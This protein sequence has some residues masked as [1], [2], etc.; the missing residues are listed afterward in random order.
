TQ[1]AEALTGAY[2]AILDGE[3]VALDSK[4]VPS[5][6]R[7]QPRMHVSDESTVRKLRKSTPVIYQVFDLLYADG[8]DLTR[9]PLRERLRRLDEA[10]TPMGDPPQ[11]GLRRNG[12]RAL[13]GREGAGA[14]GDHRQAPRLHLS[15][16]RALARVGEGEGVPHDGLR[17]RRMDRGT[18]WPCEHPWRA[19]SRRIPRR[20]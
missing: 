11:R 16:R 17:R 20:K 13:R 12:R 2:H 5:F 19:T 9:K 8:E 4:G 15:A 14:R 6:Q 10:L 3:I 7:L 18:G 1:A